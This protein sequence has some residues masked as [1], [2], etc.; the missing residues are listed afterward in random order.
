MVTCGEGVGVAGAI[1]CVVDG[2][3][4]VGAGEFTAGDVAGA[5]DATGE[6]AV[7]GSTAGEVG[8]GEIPIGEV[9]VVVPGDGV[10]LLP[11]RA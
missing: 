3:V 6:P 10:W 4:A 1:S 5:V 9:G 7:A 2:V 8:I 11:A